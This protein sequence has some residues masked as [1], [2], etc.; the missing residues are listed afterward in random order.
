MPTHRCALVPVHVRV[1]AHAHVCACV[2]AHECV[3]L[4]RPRRLRRQIPEQLP[5][6]LV[7]SGAHVPGGISPPDFALLIGWTPRNSGT[8]C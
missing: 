5:L 3:S 4:L 1:P 2:R 6:N 7:N 8:L